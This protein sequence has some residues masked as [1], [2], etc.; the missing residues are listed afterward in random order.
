MICE[1]ATPLR[2]VPRD[3]AGL[4]PRRLAQPSRTACQTGLVKPD[5]AA[6]RQSQA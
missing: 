1:L 3:L 4:D 6:A 2:E 5:L